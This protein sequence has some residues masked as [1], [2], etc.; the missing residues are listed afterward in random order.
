[1]RVAFFLNQQSINQIR[2]RNEFRVSG[3]ETLP[4]GIMISSSTLCRSSLA[5]GS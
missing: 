1:M 3:A 5:Q 4:V 2:L